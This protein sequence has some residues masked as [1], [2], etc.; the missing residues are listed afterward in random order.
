[1]NDVQQV[2]GTKP[3]KFNLTTTLKEVTQH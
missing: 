3:T 1:M 2:R